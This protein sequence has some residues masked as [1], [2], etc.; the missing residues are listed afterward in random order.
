MSAIVSKWI[1]VLTDPFFPH[2]DDQSVD[3]RYR[4]RRN[5]QWDR[6]A[7]ALPDGLG[8]VHEDTSGTSR[9]FCKAIAPLPAIHLHADM[10]RSGAQPMKQTIRDAQHGV[11]SKIINVQYD[12]TTSPTAAAAAA[13]AGQLSCRPGLPGICDA[14]QRLQLA[15]GAPDSTARRSGMAASGLHG[16]H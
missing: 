10:E 2:L 12:L 14:E 7:E 5:T 6:L 8:D 15:L 1:V 13:S 3:L 4:Q 9:S 16:R 11:I